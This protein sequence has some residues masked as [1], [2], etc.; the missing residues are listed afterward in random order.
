MQFI[1]RALFG[2][3]AFS[4]LAACGSGDDAGSGSGSDAPSNVSAETGGAVTGTIHRVGAV[5]AI[6][7]AASSTSS[8]SGAGTSDDSSQAGTAATAVG[9]TVN[10]S[11]LAVTSA[12]TV[13]AA[14]TPTGS[15][16]TSATTSTGSAGT[17]ATTL[18]N[19]PLLNTVEKLG[20]ATATQAAAGLGFNVEP[21]NDWEFQMAAAAGATW[22]RFQCGWS[23]TETQTAPPANTNGSTRFVLDSG[24]Q[25][26]LA[27][28]RKYGLK[29]TVLAAYGS[30]YHAILQVS[31]PSGAAAGSKKLNV[32]LVTGVGGDSLNN[33]AFPNDTIIAT[34]GQQIS[35]MHSYAGALITG[36]TLTSP[37]TA[38]LTLASAL[39]S[40]LPASNSVS[41]TINEYLH[42]PAASFSPTDPSNLAFAAYAAFLAQSIA[43]ANL[44]GE[45]ELWNE[46][47]WPDDPWDDRADFYDD[48]PATSNPTVLAP[49]FMPNF[50]FVAAIQA[51]GVHYSGVTFVWGGTEKSGASSLFNWMQGDTGVALAQPTQS[52]TT[53][54]MHPYGN[55]PEDSLW[56]ESCLEGTVPS[57]P[58]PALP[59][60]P[61]N[62]NGIPGG[63]ASLGEQF[64][65]RQQSANSTWG[66]HREITE[67]GFPAAYG[68]D[69]HKARFIS[70]QFLG[71]EAAGVTPI[72]FYRL[73]DNSSY[74]WGFVSQ[75]ASANGSHAANAAYT[76]VSGLISDLKSISAQAPVATSA[77]NLPQVSQYSGTYPLDMVTFVG[78]KPGAAS[79]S[80]LMTLWQRSNGANWGAL[81]SPAATSVTVVIPQNTVVSAVINV[82]TRATVA[83]SRIGQTLTLQ[84]SDDPVEILLIPGT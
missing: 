18:V 69:L 71:Y 37:S 35:V 82:D 38:T 44:Q 76:T 27:S 45:V 78:A 4:L 51:Q 60:S 3:C 8:G 52:V 9:A 22:V 56:I 23:G 70:R 21:S 33:I 62:L 28:A 25:A 13:P 77:A 20:I 46:P 16:G 64:S 81:A 12:T 68:D 65:L 47:P 61:C 79:N 42:A 66:V 49:P 55:S 36:V 1:H 57:Y 24:C 19:T 5:N 40:N 74:N 39:T 83:Y 80:Y 11:A 72:E 2:A 59:F 26:G 31:L 67:T 53:E 50:G 73:F 6:V 7:A 75:T 54:S 84:V 14:V 15:A 17:S 10:T 63:N 58:L 43:N 48:P 41:Y 29:P 30:P 32:T 34:S